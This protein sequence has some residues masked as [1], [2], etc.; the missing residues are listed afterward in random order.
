MRLTLLALTMVLTACAFDP[1]GP[2]PIECVPVTAVYFTFGPDAEEPVRYDG[3]GTEYDCDPEYAAFCVV[4]VP[5]EAYRADPAGTIRGATTKQ[6]RQRCR[7]LA[8]VPK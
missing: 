6:Q 2:R 4:F 7:P 8:I 3:S 1:F 5:A